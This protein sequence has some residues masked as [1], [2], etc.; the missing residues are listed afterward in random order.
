[1]TLLIVDD[2]P[3]SVEGIANTVLAASMDFSSIFKAYSMKQAQ[4]VFSQHTV[5]ILISDIEMPHGSGID[6]VEWVRSQEYDTTCIFLTSFSKF[7][8]ASSAIKLKIFDY[9]LKPC[10][11]SQ[12]TDTLSSAINDVKVR[13]EKKKKERSGEYWEETYQSR[14]N[15]FWQKLLLNDIPSEYSSLK[16]EIEWQHLD[17]SLMDNSYYELILTLIP[18]NV[19]SDWKDEYSWKYALNNIVAEI[20]HSSSSFSYENIY[21]III[22]KKDFPI[23]EKFYASCE[24]LIKAIHSVFPAECIGYCSPACSITN[25]NAMGQAM[26]FELSEKNSFKSTLFVKDHD[27]TPHAAPD[28]SDEKWKNALIS[29]EPDVII[30]DMRTYFSKP[31]YTQYYD[32]QTMQNIYH[33]LLHVIYDVLKTTNLSL[34][35]NLLSENNSSH[36][37]VYRNIHEFIRWTEKITSEIAVLISEQNS[38]ASMIHSLVNYIHEHL[39]ENLS[40]SKLTQIVHLHPDYLSAVF[41]QKM[42]ISLSEYVNEARLEKA[43][44]LLLTT[45]LS[46]SQV[47]I[48]AGFPNISYFSKLFREREGITPLQYRKKH[49]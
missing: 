36:S 20:L 6:L 41:H 22:T 23:A 1:M 10:E 38:S 47:A 40:R 8:Y 24:K 18:D 2:E 4:T 37:V 25:L 33:Q 27:Y 34:P 48:Q 28:F 15:Q 46:V 35:Q 19:M 45:N 13:Q 9:V 17:S 14:L 30:N 43:R 42:G 11:S 7:E 32:N 21:T 31:C 5:D 16:K 29:N 44:K 12:L 49:L 39:D 26:R 3:L